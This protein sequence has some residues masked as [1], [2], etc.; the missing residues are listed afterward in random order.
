MRLELLHRLRR[1][2]DER[3]A[4]ALSTTILSPESEDRDLVFAGFVEF[5]ELGSEFV[6]GDVGAVGV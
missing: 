2:I 1:V 6:F 3:K 4:G 5:G